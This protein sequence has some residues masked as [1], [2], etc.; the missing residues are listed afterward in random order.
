MYRSK[1]DA[2]TLTIVDVH[3][4]EG[5]LRCSAPGVHAARIGP[6]GLVAV[7]HRR[8]HR[9]ARSATCVGRRESREE[10]ARGVACIARALGLY[11]GVVAGLQNSLKQNYAQAHV[12]GSSRG[13]RVLLNDACCLRCEVRSDRCCAARVDRKACRSAPSIRSPLLLGCS[14]RGALRVAW[15]AGP[16]AA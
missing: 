3:L 14:G 12:L 2:D 1:D 6:C 8:D 16:Q 11:H 7:R 10:E 4:E 13:T 15:R 9:S 5:A